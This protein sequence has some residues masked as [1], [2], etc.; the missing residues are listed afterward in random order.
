MLK[1][2]GFGLVAGLILGAMGTVAAMVVVKET[3]PEHAGPSAPIAVVCG[4]KHQEPVPMVEQVRGGQALE[5]P[6]MVD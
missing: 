1:G 2:N 4:C 3:E 5:V 6:A